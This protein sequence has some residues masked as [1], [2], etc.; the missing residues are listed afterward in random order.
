[1]CP[2]NR[3]SG[4]TRGTGGHDRNQTP[5]SATPLFQDGSDHIISASLQMWTS[6]H[7]IPAKMVEHALMVLIHRASVARRDIVDPTAR[8]ERVACCFWRDMHVYNLQ[9]SASHHWPR[10][11]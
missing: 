2:H 9:W 7:P 10:D 3:G 6:A 11:W 5:M 1:M 8:Q 4:P